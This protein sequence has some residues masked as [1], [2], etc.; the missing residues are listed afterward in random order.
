MKTIYLIHDKQQNFFKIGKTT[1]KNIKQRL[2]NLNTGNSATLY[3][4][5]SFSYELSDNLPTSLETLIHKKYKDFKINKE[6]FDMFLGFSTLDEIVLDFLKN[7][8]F[9]YEMLSVFKTSIT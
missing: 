6:W 8:K 2:S 9:Y 3:V 1:P 5:S 4:L 7:C